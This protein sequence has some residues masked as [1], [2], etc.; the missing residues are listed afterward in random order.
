MDFGR[1]KT[2]EYYLGDICKTYV[3][4]C[5]QIR[6]CFP[7]KNPSNHQILGGMDP[8]WAQSTPRWGGVFSQQDFGDGPRG[9]SLK[10]KTSG[11]PMEVFRGF[12][13]QFLAKACGQT[14]TIS[15]KNKICF[16]ASLRCYQCASVKTSEDRG[17]LP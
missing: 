15:E 13:S 16:T 8:P 11:K 12:G 4:F 7:N 14:C 3:F 1:R 9:C 2:L 6:W 10:G 17:Q 5:H